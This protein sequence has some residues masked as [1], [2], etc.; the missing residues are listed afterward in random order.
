MKERLQKIISA[1][2]VCSR[3]AAEKLIEAGTVTVNGEIATLGMS[4][5]PD[6][7]VIAVDGTLLT[8]APEPEYIL[9][10]KPRGVLTASSDDR[11]RRTVTDLVDCGERVYPVGRLD[12]TSEGL[13]IL[14]NDGA[15]ARALTHPSSRVPKTYR[16]T[17]EPYS[18]QA[19]D[20]LRDMDTL[21]GEPIERAK[22]SLLGRN[23]TRGRLE[24]VITQ[25]KNRQIR[26]MCAAAGMDVLRLR[27]VKIGELTLGG[28]EP[29]EW[30]KLEKKEIRYL[31]NLAKSER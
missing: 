22:V 27:R 11:G 3:R 12:L 20:A 4:A 21:D 9:L 8:A 14:T 2:G 7:D 31:K 29:G 30:R 5:D 19:L 26:R 15:L 25:G 16:V 13:I 10:N 17:V 6:A 23:G 1:Y 18:E 24:I 28:L